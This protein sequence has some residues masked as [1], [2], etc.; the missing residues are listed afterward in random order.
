MASTVIQKISMKKQ[1]IFE[2]RRRILTWPQLYLKRFYKQAKHYRGPQTNLTFSP[3]PLTSLLAILKNIL[4]LK[5]WT[6]SNQ[7]FS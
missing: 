4:E 3:R 2:G 5:E 7:E 1:N 6:N